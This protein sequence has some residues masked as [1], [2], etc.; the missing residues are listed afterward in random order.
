M[1]DRQHCRIGSG[2]GVCT[3]TGEVTYEDAAVLRRLLSGMLRNPEIDLIVIDARGVT[4][5]EPAPLAELI[6]A[7]HRMASGGRR[8]VIVDSGG[9]VTK[10]LRQVGLLHH[11]QVTDELPESTGRCKPPGNR[12]G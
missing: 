10:E 5:I 3:L 4:T 12:A 8:V 9:T 1:S 11:F 2:P 7:R 6:T